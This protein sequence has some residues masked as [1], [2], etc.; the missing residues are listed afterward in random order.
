MY[1]RNKSSGPLYPARLHFYTFVILVLIR[2]L[3]SVGVF[4]SVV[5]GASLRSRLTPPATINMKTMG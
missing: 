3:F 1:D 5:E 2:V 4:G